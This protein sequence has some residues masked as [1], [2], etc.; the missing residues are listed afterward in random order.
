MVFH[1]AFEIYYLWLPIIGFIIGMLASLIGSGGSFFVLITLL[2]VFNV[3]PQIAVATSLAA[4]LPVCLIGSIRHFHYGNINLRMGLLFGVA[5]VA[6]ALLGAQVTGL[7]SPTELKISF[8]IYI[9][10][11]ALKMFFDYQ[12]KK[13]SKDNNLSSGKIKLNARRI[14]I[15]SV[16]GFMGGIVTGTFGTSGAAPVLAGL[17]SLRVPVKQVAGTS[18]LVIL[19]YTVFALSAHFVVG[20]V[21]LT[22]V[23]FLASG[24]TLGAFSGPR[25]LSGVSLGGKESSVRLWYA[26]GLAIIGVVMI[27]DSIN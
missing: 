14:S 7:I 24:A 2:L 5:G 19:V 12:Q 15:G 27:I 1:S 23:Y 17:L 16:Y 21:D 3:S 11:L 9:F 13:K 4:T 6:G 8:G 26:V 22:L 18:L 25:L 10:V 20:K